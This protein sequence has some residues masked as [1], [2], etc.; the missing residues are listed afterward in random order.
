MEDDTKENKENTG[1]KEKAGKEFHGKLEFFEDFLKTLGLDVDGIS[2][3]IEKLEKAKDA[4]ASEAYLMAFHELLETVG[5]STE[6]A[7]PEIKKF[8]KEIVG[9]LTPIV[10]VLIKDSLIGMY[11]YAENM[12]AEATD[13]TMETHKKM[14][15][16]NANLIA[17]EIQCLEGEGLSRKEAMEII[18]A[19]I[20]QPKYS[21]TSFSPNYI[22]MRKDGSEKSKKE[23]IDDFVNLAKTD[24]RVL[25]KMVTAIKGPLGEFPGMG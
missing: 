12:R 11:I 1:K 14:N 5:D 21:P 4:N 15:K 6:T 19:K 16:L 25:I 22:T 8:K 18:K 13:G 17:D 23:V 3:K 10:D 2:E 9:I 20:S 7:A 24:P